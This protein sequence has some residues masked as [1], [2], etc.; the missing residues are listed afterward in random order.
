M[1]INFRLKV[2]FVIYVS[3]ICVLQIQVENCFAQV[4]NSPN[5]V[6]DSCPTGKEHNIWFLGSNGFDFN[7]GKPEVIKGF[8]I[9]SKVSDQAYASICDR[10]GEL[11]L[12]CDHINLY[13]KFHQ[14]IINPGP[15]FG[16]WGAVHNIVMVPSPGND[17]IIYVI[18]PEGSQNSRDDIRSLWMSVVDLNAN[19]G[20]G[21]IIQ[22]AIKL[23][24]G[25]SSSVCATRHCNGK[26]WWIIGQE[27]EEFGE[28]FYAWLLTDKGIDL[29]NPVISKTIYSFPPNL[30]VTLNSKQGQLKISPDG[31]F[32]CEPTYVPSTGLE[33]LELYH[34]N[35][36]TGEITNGLVIINAFRPNLY[37]NQITQD[38]VLYSEFSP[39]ASKL[40]YGSIY[41]KQLDLN[42]LN[43]NNLCDKTTILLD[44]WI[45]PQGITDAFGSAALGPDGKIYLGRWG[46]DTSLSIIHN[47]NELGINCNFQIKGIS[48]ECIG[49]FGTPYIPGRSMWPNKLFIRGPKK[50]C[51][52]STVEFTISD[53]CD[54][55]PTQ[56]SILDNG[57]VITSIR[58]DSIN[59]QFYKPGKYRIRAA[60]ETDCAL[61]TDTFT[62]D[63]KKCECNSFIQW[64]EYDSLVCEGGNAKFIFNTNSSNVLINNIEVF[65][66]LIELDSLVK[67]TCF[68]INFKYP[69]YCDT[70]IDICIK[71]QNKNN[72]VHN[73]QLCMGDSILLNGF[74]IRND[75]TYDTYYKN[76]NQCDSIIKTKINFKV[77][78]TTRIELHFCKGDTTIIGGKKISDAQKLIESYKSSS[79]CIDS[80]I[81]YN[82]VF[83]NRALLTKHIIQL[84]HGDSVLYNNKL[85]KED[86]IFIDTIR[87]N[88]ICDSLIEV[89]I[90]VKPKL[91]TQDIFYTLC[92]GDSIEIVRPSEII[93]IKDNS[94]IKDNWQSING[95]DSIIFYHI[96]KLP[97]YETIEKIFKCKDDS[98]FYSGNFYSS[99]IIISKKYQS[100]TL[101][102]SFHRVEILNYPESNPTEE[103]LSSCFNDSIQFK[104][105]WFKSDTVILS[106]QNNQNGC[107]SAHTVNIHFVSE[108]K[109]RILNYKICLG[110]SINIDGHWYKDTIQLN[111]TYINSNG[112]DSIVS[113]NIINY[114]VSPATHTIHKI[115]NGDSIQID[116]IWYH[117]SSTLI[118]QFNNQYGCDSFHMTEVQLYP[119]PEPTVITFY[120]CIGDSV[121]IEQLWYTTAS[122]F[123]VHKSSIQSCDSVIQYRV[124]PYED[125]YVDLD[126]T[127][128]LIR[129]GTHTLSGLHAMNVTRFRWFPTEYLSCTDCPNPKIKAIQDGTY[130]L[131]VS[132]ANGCTAI[133]SIF[134]HVKNQRSEIFIPNIFSPNADSKNDTWNITFS[135]SKSKIISLQVFERWGQQ[136]YSCDSYPN[137]MGS[138]CNG[139]DG[140]VNNR[141]CLPNVYIYLINWEN[142]A[143]QR[144]LI[145]GDV[146]LLR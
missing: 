89:S 30:K 37:C 105:K 13:N 20:K 102:D 23:L 58:N 136:V 126:D 33:S 59:V 57:P 88:R 107:D 78:D 36:S 53:P 34:F 3:L 95:C 67:D 5:F 122:E 81:E 106:L 65:S 141:L 21:K 98:I 25:S 114:P 97:K 115:C 90:N 69:S 80:I 2:I 109:P 51:P 50:I 139:W 7:N 144:F 96:S 42:G 46:G 129:G 75:T 73:Y 41:V 10:N 125:L 132:D 66:N 93:N 32:L 86:S 87:T 123:T 79:N 62:I 117:D 121:Q 45:R 137:G 112:C 82:I 63:V 76:I 131:E 118:T 74:W 119:I 138:N 19:S 143:G 99:P 128:E 127:L 103:F 92:D 104:G 52:D 134:I 140:M 71:V 15:A 124:I 116:N 61:K 43:A 111:R 110:D 49:G 11:L 145:N 146:T 35:S 17:S 133:D 70:I 101:C 91:P 16:I 83:E 68:Q 60:Y 120:F 26:D 135:D 4:L 64:L 27:V 55:N 9:N 22:N 39:D 77:I 48:R 1:K 54:H 44:Q 31:R 85:Y 12:Y 56:W 108:I 72:P 113:I 142:A 94:D 28:D 130:Y 84:C 8:G 100:N 29:S 6:K 47:P 40:Y 14:K 24:N 38:D 18:S